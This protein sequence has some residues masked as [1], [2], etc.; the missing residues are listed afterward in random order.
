MNLGKLA[1]KSV[2]SNASLTT[3]FALH[4]L[5]CI[6]IM[7][8]ALWFI[9][10]NYLINQIL[11]REWRTTAQ[12]VRADVRIFLEEYDF[13]AQDRKSV[14]PKFAALLEHM[15]LAPECAATVS[16]DPPNSRSLTTETMCT[17][18]AL[19]RAK[20]VVWGCHSSGSTC[21]SHDRWLISRF[22]PGMRAVKPISPWASRGRQA[23]AEGRQASSRSSTARRRCRS[24]RLW[25][26]RREEGGA[27]WA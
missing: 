22:V 18:A 9:V 15:R 10:S 26:Q 8:V 19:S 4:S 20:A 7:T 16:P 21:L 6:S 5:V 2:Y 24:I 27:A 14:G 23:G 13:K 12:I 11:D 25:T 1:L 3:R 17:P